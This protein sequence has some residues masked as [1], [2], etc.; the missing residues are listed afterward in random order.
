M[1][2]AIVGF[3][4]IGQ[5]LAPGRAG[6]A[7]RGWRAGARS[8]RH[9]GPAHLRGFVQEGA[10][11]D[12]RLCDLAREVRFQNVRLNRTRSNIKKMERL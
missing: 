8:R 10:V 1:N 5:A 6:K 12:L 3:G 4:K 11:I 7:E 9:L 2:Y